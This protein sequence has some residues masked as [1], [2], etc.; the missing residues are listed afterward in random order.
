MAGICTLFSVGDDDLT[1]TASD[2]TLSDW[3]SRT[4]AAGGKPHVVELGTLW[5]PLHAALGGHGPDH[6]L[7]FLLGGGTP[8]APLDEGA[9]SQGR[10]F[11]PAQATKMLAAIA[12]MTDDR[13]M[14]GAADS[15]VEVSW[16]ELMRVLVRLRVFFADAVTAD[17]G[18]V[19]HH[20][21]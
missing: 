15:G 1:A 10:Y 16:L 20:L 12:R 13:L 21:R 5:Q 11:A 9:H 2:A 8:F 4:S 7:G 17:H 14:R 3:D 18:V 6:V 19:V